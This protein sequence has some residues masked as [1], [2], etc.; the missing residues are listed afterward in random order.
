MKEKEKDIFIALYEFKI[1]P[2]K[3]DDFRKAWLKTTKGI[4]QE[5]G[6]LGSRLH[7]TEKENIYI[8]YAQWPNREKWSS[9]KVEL[10][11]EYLS[12]WEEMK[13]CIEESK[14]LYEMEVTD[15]YLHT[16]AFNV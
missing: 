5:F 15:D 4:Y 10:S 11:V 16:V 7:S 12:A 9:D 1:K 13:E 6:S 14:T 2:G 8:G 3:E